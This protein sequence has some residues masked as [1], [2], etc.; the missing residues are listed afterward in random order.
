MEYKDGD[1]V[2]IAPIGQWKGNDPIECRV[3]GDQ[4]IQDYVSF[5]NN[6]L[7]VFHSAFKHECF[8]DSSAIFFDKR[9]ADKYSL[10]HSVMQSLV[11]DDKRKIASRRATIESEWDFSLI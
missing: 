7:W 3:V 5:P 1:I 9:I 10:I 2:Y 11:D 4:S 8:V 6:K